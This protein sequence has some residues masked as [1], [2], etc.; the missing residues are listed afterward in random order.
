M[1]VKE[2]VL[3][4]P[5]DDLPMTDAEEIRERIGSH[6]DLVID[7][8][9]G[10]TGFTTVVDLSDELPQVVREGI[11]DLSVFADGGGSGGGPASR[12]RFDA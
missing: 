12:N 4:M 5:G 6:C 2:G 10:S 7:G 3:V 8:G 1:V 9:P 11:G